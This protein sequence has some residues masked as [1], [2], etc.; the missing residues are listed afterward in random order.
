MAKVK[1]LL[2]L[3]VLVATMFMSI[4][5][6]DPPAAAP[7]ATTV[8]SSAADYKPFGMLIMSVAVLLKI[9]PQPMLQ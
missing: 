2:V 7:A 1:L 5:A 4:S 9:L 8:A 3:F 6:D